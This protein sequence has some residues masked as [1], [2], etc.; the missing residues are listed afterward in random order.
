MEFIL[1]RQLFIVRAVA[2]AAISAVNGAIPLPEKRDARDAILVKDTVTDYYKQLG[3]PDLTPDNFERFHEFEGIL[4]RYNFQ[5]NKQAILSLA[6]QADRSRKV[7]D[8]CKYIPIVGTTIAGSI[9]FALMLRYLVRCVNKLEE[10]ALA[11][12]DEAAKKNKSIK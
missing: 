2:A 11:V 9:S 8:V 4:R 10:L 7:Q 5:P 3:I 6:S 1:C 12:W